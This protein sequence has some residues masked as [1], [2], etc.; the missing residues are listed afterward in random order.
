MANLIKLKWL[1]KKSKKVYEE[2]MSSKR[3]LQLL[4]NLKRALECLPSLR[5][6]ILNLMN[7]KRLTFKRH[8]LKIIKVLS[9]HN[10]K[11]SS[12]GL[13]LNVLL[14]VKKGKTS[15]LILNSIGMISSQSGLK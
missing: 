2:F 9:N 4:L 3:S 5:K 6:R 14:I 12:I 13:I 8:S 15:L 10:N 11:N 1:I 7:L